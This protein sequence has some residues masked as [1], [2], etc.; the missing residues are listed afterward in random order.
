M[1][2]ARVMANLK[3]HLMILISHCA[4]CLLSRTW[5]AT[6][7]SRLILLR[8]R[9]VP[10]PLPS[11]ACRQEATTESA[12]YV[13]R[14]TQQGW[15]HNWLFQIDLYVLFQHHNASYLTDINTEQNQTSWQS[16]TMDENVHMTLVNLTVNMSKDLYVY[17]SLLNFEFQKRL[18]TSPM[19]GWN[20]V[21]LVP[22]VLQST[23]RSVTSHG[24]LTQTQRMAGSLGSTIPPLVWTLTGSRNLSPSYSQ[25]MREILSMPRRLVRTG[26][27]APQSSQT[28]LP[29]PAEMWL[30]LLWMVGLVLTTLTTTG[31]YSTGSQQQIS[32]INVGHWIGLANCLSCPQDFTDAFEHFW[33]WS[34]WWS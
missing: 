27:S 26:H 14:M 5:S 8:W 7:Q 13:T 28:Y 9:V 17:L 10:E 21:L 12:R 33:R 32:G 18:L 19:S 2:E 30:L 11:T 34:V 20:S 16:V 24:S 6:L 1:R 3:I 29:S 31:N 4:A 22:R 15:E 25:Y 23:R